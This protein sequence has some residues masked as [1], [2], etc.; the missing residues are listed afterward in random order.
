MTLNIEWQPTDEQISNIKTFIDDGEL[1]SSFE[2]LLLNKIDV[3]NK[4]PQVRL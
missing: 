4:K 1:L 2:K 3:S